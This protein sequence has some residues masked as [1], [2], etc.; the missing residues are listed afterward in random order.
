MSKMSSSLKSQKPLVIPSVDRTKGM[1]PMN[2]SSLEQVDEAFLAKHSFCKRLNNRIPLLPICIFFLIIMIII[3]ISF[4]TFFCLTQ[5]QIEYVNYLINGKVEFNKS[6]GYLLNPIR[7]FLGLSINKKNNNMKDLIKEIMKKIEEENESYKN[8]NKSSAIVSFNLGDN[9]KNDFEYEIIPLVVFSLMKNNVLPYKIV[10]NINK[11]NKKKIITKEI[12]DLI[13]KEI[14]EIIEC[15]LDL[16]N[17]N[18]YYYPS[19]KYY[20]NPIIICPSSY[21]FPNDFIED[22]IT[23]YKKNPEVIHSRRTLLKIYGKN[24]KLKNFNKWDINPNIKDSPSFNFFS[25]TAGGILIPPNGLNCSISNKNDLEM[26][27]KLDSFE[28][29]LLNYF[30]LRNKMKIKFIPPK[31]Y[32]GIYLMKSGIVNVKE[33]INKIIKERKYKKNKEIHKILKSVQKKIKE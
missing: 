22:L 7:E 3:L 18:K 13:N 10:F 16:K 14:I 1:N 27:K 26:I 23:S 17:F 6:S 28:D 11:D 19:I 30:L 9:G 12:E 20:A 8:K 2:A 33:K 29:F 15:D 5:Y 25:E 21:L 31:K 24:N 32:L 4:I